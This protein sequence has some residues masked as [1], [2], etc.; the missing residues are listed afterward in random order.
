MAEATAAASVGR[1][2]V[3]QPIWLEDDGTLRLRCA[4]TIPGPRRSARL[5]SLFASRTVRGLRYALHPFSRADVF[6]VGVSLFVG[7]VLASPSESWLRAG[8]PASA[9]WAWSEAR[10][11][12]PHGAATTVRVGVL[13]A[14]MAVPALLLLAWAQRSVLWL[15]L[16]DSAWLRAARSPTLYVRGWFAAVH[17]LTRGAPLTESFQTSLPRQPVP[18]LRVTVNKLLQSARLLQDDTAYAATAAAAEAFMAAEGPKLQRLLVL[19]SFFVPSYNADWWERYVYLKSRDALLINSNYYV[20]DSAAWKP[21]HNQ[22]ARAAVLVYNMCLFKDRLESQRVA[23]ILVHN[24]VPLC[25][26]QVC[27]LGGTVL[28]SH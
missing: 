18:Q 3:R 13:A 21:T 8:A 11:P 6:A 12:W 17:A 16:C 4:C 1:R 26:K 2:V 7:L 5:L 25:M 28:I 24:T 10:L 27:W 23:P 9:V 15:L 20:L 19:R 22:A 14:A